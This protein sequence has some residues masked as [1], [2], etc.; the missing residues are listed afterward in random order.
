MAVF[1]FEIVGQDKSWSID[2]GCS[3]LKESSAF[4]Q[5]IQLTNMHK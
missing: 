2:E 4:V 1:W 5:I 3:P